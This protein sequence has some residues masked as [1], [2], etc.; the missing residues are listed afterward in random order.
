MLEPPLTNNVYPVLE[1][2]YALFCK[3]HHTLLT[4]HKQT[5]HILA[6]SQQSEQVV[7]ILAPS[8]QSEQVVRIL[9][10]VSSLLDIEDRLFVNRFPYRAQVISWLIF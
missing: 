4:E 7:R 1:M 5:V 6:P 9:V 8:Q 2:A 10:T 3:S